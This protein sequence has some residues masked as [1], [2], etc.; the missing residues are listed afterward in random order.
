MKEK[1][2]Q[3]LVENLARLGI[4]GVLCGIAL[5][6]LQPYLPGMALRAELAH[7]FGFG[8]IVLYFAG[9]AITAKTYR[10]GW[11]PIGGLCALALLV[12]LPR[13]L[14]PHWLIAHGLLYF[15]GVGA[16]LPSWLISGAILLG[17]LSAGLRAEQWNVQRRGPSA[18]LHMWMLYGAVALGCEAWSLWYEL[19]QQPFVLVS[20]H[21]P[22]RGFI[23]WGQVVFDALGIW[24]AFGACLFAERTHGLA[25]LVNALREVNPG[26]QPNVRRS[27]GE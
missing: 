18:A 16:A 2:R 4:V 27:A 1:I 19:Y 5:E 26:S 25:S 21:K 24:L 14:A 11:Q 3:T 7:F 13:Y 8:G 15:G 9:I 22:P 6:S 17:I 20:F 12:V 23:E 10:L